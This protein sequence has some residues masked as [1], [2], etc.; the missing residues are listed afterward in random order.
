MVSPNI[1][2]QEVEDITMV[3]TINTLEVVNA[4]WLA[5]S[6]FKGTTDLYEASVSDLS[7]ALL[8]S[9]KINAFSKGCF[10]GS[11]PNTQRL[12]NRV[13]GG[14]MPSPNNVARMVFDSV[15]GT[16]LSSPLIEQVEKVSK[17]KKRK[18]QGIVMDEEPNATHRLD[19]IVGTSKF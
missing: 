16:P 15:D 1:V 17:N 11:G 7:Q 2:M 12:A 4:N 18:R 5:G 19:Y 13:H 6:G 8:Q 14:T 10:H 9:T 3:P